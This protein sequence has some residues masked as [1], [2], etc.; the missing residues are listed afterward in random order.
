VTDINHGAPGPQGPGWWQASDGRWYPPQPQAP[1]YAQPAPQGYPPPGPPGYGQPQAPP[2]PPK[3]SGKGCLIAL[4]I[5]LGLFVLA[6]IAFAILAAFVWN[7]AED[8]LDEIG[9]PEEAEDVD[10]ADCVTNEAGFMVAELRVTNRSPERSNYIIEVAFESPDGDT[11]LATAVAFVN[12]LA[13]DQSTDQE[14]NSLT[15]ATGDFDCRL[16]LVDRSSAE[17]GD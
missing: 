2:P 3:T 16:S 10:L 17:F 6:G 1:T 14:A 15:D 5:V 11:Q 8:A 4:A 9:D 12:D 7:R 13:P